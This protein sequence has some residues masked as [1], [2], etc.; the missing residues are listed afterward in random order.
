MDETLAKARLDV[1][2][3]LDKFLDRQKEYWTKNPEDYANTSVE[4][5]VLA[6]Y[7]DNG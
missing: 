5:I 7:E 3:D 1:L 2:Q 4:D 6:F